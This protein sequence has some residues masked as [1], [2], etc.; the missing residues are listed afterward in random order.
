MVHLLDM[1]EK[2]ARK[3]L[4]QHAAFIPFFFFMKDSQTG[5]AWGNPGES[6]DSFARAIRHLAIAK[7]ITAGMVVELLKNVKVNRP[8]VNLPPGHP[9]SQKSVAK[10]YVMATWQSRTDAVT[11][12]LPVHRNAD[13]TFSDFGEA[14]GA[15]QVPWLANIVPLQA[16]D[17]VERRSA[18]FQLQ[19]CNLK[20]GNIDI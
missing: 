13:G 2:H 10:E 7:N 5:M 9:L 3:Q 6:A 1:A 8:A 19:K 14:F 15:N 18:N 20:I 12:V 17:L 11:C 16:P 4:Q